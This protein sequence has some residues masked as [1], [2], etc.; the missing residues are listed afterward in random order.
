M[1][2][3]LTRGDVPL[4]KSVLYM[5]VPDSDER[6]VV[7][8]FARALTDCEHDLA[9]KLRSTVVDFPS[10][11]RAIG[12]LCR[13]GVVVVIDEFQYFTRT[14]LKSF[15]SFLQAEVDKLRDANI[16]HGGLFVLGSLHA[17]MNQLLEDKG[18]PLYGRLTQRMKL[19]HWDFEDLL[20]IFRSQ[21]VQA[22]S[23]WLTLWTYFEGVPKF[24]HDAFDQDLYQV[25]P[26]KFADELLT[27]MFLRSAS[28]LSEEADTWFLRELRGRLLSMLTFLADHAGCSNG[29]LL[30]GTGGPEEKTQTSAYLTKLVTNYEMVAKLNPV[31][32][33]GKSRNARYYVADNFL[34]AW[35][36]VAK[37]A[38]EAARMK[39]IEKSLEL[40]RPRLATLEGFAFE[41]LI[42]KL[43]QECS[44]KGKGDFELSSLQLGYWNRPKDT[45]LSI[46][47]DVVALDETNKRIRFGSC[48]HAAEAHTNATVAAFEKHVAGF[49]AAKQH[50]HLLE[51][52]KEMVLFSPAFSSGDRKQAAAKGYLA[53]DLH[54]YAALF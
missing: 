39:P 44:R 36:A 14:A 24:Y 33:D 3:Q 48:K 31:F 9:R 35:L 45:S 25:A 47:I 1:L 42:R 54:D 8:T 4:S 53:M 13:A 40:A 11:A 34:Q 43:H 2:S 6:D 27:R 19:D 15:N 12:E 5:Q 28:P 22:P 16:K 46:E 37:P 21:D 38:R 49:F 26:D 41:K 18:A 20:D 17:D 50:R 52:K 23:Q 10:M 7:A 32:S 30:A 51:W 29:E